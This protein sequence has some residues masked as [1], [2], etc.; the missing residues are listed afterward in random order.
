MARG[1][2][3]GRTVLIVPEVK[4]NETIGMT[5]LHVTFAE[6]LPGDAMRTILSGYQ[7][8]YSAL[9]DAVTETLPDFDDRALAGFEVVELLTEPV[10]VLADRWPRA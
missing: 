1:R 8:R 4:G 9:K 10:Y 7:G 5:L 2:N 6:N 3:D